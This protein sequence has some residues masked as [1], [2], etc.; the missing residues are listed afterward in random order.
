M[1]KTMIGSSVIRKG[2]NTAFI[3]VMEIYDETIVDENGVQIADCQHSI[4][5]IRLW[6]WQPP[7]QYKRQTQIQMHAPN[8]NTCF[9]YKYHQIQTKI[10]VPN[11]ICEQPLRE[12]LLVV[13]GWW[14][15]S[16]PSS[17][18]AAPHSLLHTE[19]QE[20]RLFTNVIHQQSW[21]MSGT[22]GIFPR[23][24]GQFVFSQC[25]LAA[26]VLSKICGYM[27]LHW[28]LLAKIWTNRNIQNRE[29]LDGNLKK[30]K[31]SQK[32]ILLHSLK[33]ISPWA[34]CRP[35]W[36]RNQL[37]RSSSWRARL[38]GRRPSAWRRPR[39]WSTR[40]SRSPTW[41]QSPWWS[42]LVEAPLCSPSSSPATSL[43]GTFFAFSFSSSWTHWSHR[44]H[45]RSEDHQ[46]SN[47]LWSQ[48]QRNWSSHLCL[49]RGLRWWSFFFVQHQTPHFRD[50]P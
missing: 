10:H 32:E 21:Q 42:T 23:L 13:G 29:I 30:S 4:S 14:V 36:R 35:L 12:M 49:C 22:S 19:W 25:S 5:S 1:T 15:F 39:R 27:V 2:E 18:R 26:T 11:I 6:Q 38:A 17:I 34:V 7:P 9:T 43:T 48:E 37:W 45:K 47:H 44:H 50:H 41:W 46:N 3:F 40:R 16:R 28:W 31:W 33:Y 20:A 24:G 8:T